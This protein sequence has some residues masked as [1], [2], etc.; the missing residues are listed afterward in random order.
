MSEQQNQLHGLLDQVAGPICR[1]S[2]SGCMEL[3]LSICISNQCLGDEDTCQSWTILWEWVLAPG[4]T[5]ISCFTAYPSQV[6]LSP[7]LSPLITYQ[8]FWDHLASK[9][10]VL[11]QF[12]FGGLLL[13]K[14]RI[15]QPTSKQLFLLWYPRKLPCLERLGYLSQVTRWKSSAVSHF[16]TLTSWHKASPI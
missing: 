1:V 15:R 4:V 14:H 13:G 3:D 7:S 12:L 9:L 6:A 5:V 8:C 16:M 10:F 11:S 2:D